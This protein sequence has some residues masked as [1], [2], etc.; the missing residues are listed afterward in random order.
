[1]I[2]SSNGILMRWVLLVSSIPLLF[3][4]CLCVGPIEITIKEIFQSFF[5]YSASSPS[6]YII[7]HSRLPMAIA[8]LSSGMALSIAGLLMQTVF[9]N[10]LAGP[11]IL[12]VSSGASLGV[13]VCVIL[14]SGS[15]YSVSAGAFI[16]GLA[17]IAV[18]AG[19]SS[20]IKNGLALLIAGIMISYLTSAGISILNFFAPAS[21]VKLF[22]VWG[23]G[24]YLGLDLQ[25][26]IIF[27]LL[28]GVIVVLGCGLIKP[29]D[30]M[31]LGERYMGNMGYNVVKMRSLLLLMSGVLA[32]ITTLYCG[33]IG[34]V[35]LVA[36]HVARMWFR[37]AGHF[38]IY[39]A[40]LFTGAFISLLCALLSVIPV[41]FGIL[42]VNAVT[43]IIGVP[44]IIYLLTAGR[45]ISYLN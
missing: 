40:S 24:S 33:P 3:F 7:I 9:H 10:P 15:A 43:P 20:V 34:F 39:P 31:L 23:M 1:M 8:A 21:D 2:N 45:K 28:S 41:G 42:P 14:F 4:L 17:V 30:A 16:G 5:Q 35:G 44:I 32:A 25:S 19:L 13:C 27:L 29:L 26:A 12:G 11:S 38:K 6:H 36:P 18:L 37:S 22:T